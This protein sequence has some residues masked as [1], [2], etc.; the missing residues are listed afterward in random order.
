MSQS[1]TVNQV[2]IE[3]HEGGE[4]FTFFGI[5]AVIFWQYP[6]LVTILKPLRESLGEPLYSALI[7]Y[8]STKGTYEDYHAMVE[9]LG[10]DFESGFMNWGR[11]VSGAGW[12]V[13][14]LQTIDWERAQAAVRIDRPW[15]LNL[16]WP[17]DP[18]YAVPFLA[19]K[20]SGIFS[21]AFAT[22]CRARVHELERT[23]AGDPYVVLSI[24]PSSDTLE[25]ELRT[26]RERHGLSKDQSLQLTTQE[27]RTQLDRFVG[28][29]QAVGEFIWESDRSLR[30]VYSTERIT[31]ALG[32]RV[33][34]LDRR[35]GG[36]VSVWLAASV[37]PGIDGSGGCIVVSFHDL[38]E[39]KRLE[40]RL[41]W[42]A[43]HDHLTSL[44]NRG[45]FERLL[46]YELERAERYGRPVS[47]VLF[48]IDH[49]KR[50]N[51]GH[52]H[53]HGHAAGDA[54]LRELAGRL[55]A[56]L[57]GS[58]VLSRWGGEEFAVLVPETNA[59]GARLLAEKLRETIAHKPFPYGVELTIS[60][61]VAELVPGTS[62][63]GLTRAADNALYQAKRA[64]RN[65]VVVAD[66]HRH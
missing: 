36:T 51:D 55:P 8:E 1:I 57:R 32:R 60:L 27:L 24:A 4:G 47:L 64:G 41:E 7:A 25:D 48:D 33:R 40:R 16:F 13:F 23:L 58:D 45:Q 38:S 26:V 9:H 63:Q 39:H 19:G 14:D 2:P 30:L 50:V 3:W 54:V 12:G 11:A 6:S 66:Q 35:R 20:L 43:T 34:V 31:D 56:Y 17:V 5:E 65:C 15:E 46:D 10:S 52:G 49:F 44:Y 62:G 59:E 42:E 61:G 21:W 22:Y 18:D 28:V 29:V 53:G 37:S